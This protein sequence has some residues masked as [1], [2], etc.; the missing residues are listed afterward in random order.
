MHL[1]ADD[2]VDLAEGARPES[3]APHLAA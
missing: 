3:S 1:N 2:L